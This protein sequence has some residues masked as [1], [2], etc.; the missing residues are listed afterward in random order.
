MVKSRAHERET[1]TVV[2]CI[3]ACLVWIDRLRLVQRFSE[4]IPPYT[5]AATCTGY[6]IDVLLKSYIFAV[7]G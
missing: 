2:H 4:G 6:L 1:C 5:V 7:G 3:S